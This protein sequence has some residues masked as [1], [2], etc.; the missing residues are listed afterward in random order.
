MIA[1]FA[2][3]ALALSTPSRGAEVSAVRRG[4]LVVRVRVSGTVVPDDIFRLKSTIEGRVESV[5]ASSY[6]WRGADQ[7]LAF[8]AHKELAAIVDA[9]GSQTQELLE[10][11]WERVY[12]P[13][14]LRCP[15]AC[16][17]LKVYAKAKSWVKPQAVLFEAAAKLKMVARV[18]PEDAHWVQDGQL[19]TF[20]SVKDPKKTYQGRVNRYILDVQ[21]Q[22]V[23]PG[24]SFTL[25][26][27]PT[28][29]F[30]PGTAWEGEIVAAERKDV[31]TVPTSALIRHG[32]SVYLPVLV[33]TGVTTA[34]LTQITSGIEE[35]H[36]ILIIDD[37]QLKGEERHKQTVDRDALEKRREALAPPAPADDK[38]Y[39]DDPY[40]EP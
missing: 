14:P 26:L 13:T 6:T 22:K 8:L 18:R 27:S 21:G 15:A 37:A 31:L 9:K 40:G 11:R 23:D 7:P 34:T 35:R 19:L 39:G 38:D 3:L 17:I 10:D 2:A 36:G 24:G 30:D 20:W 4:D 28:R 33:S 25:D 12:R 16:F 29:Y 32:D 5:N 1:A